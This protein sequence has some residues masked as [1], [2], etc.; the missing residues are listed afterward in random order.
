MPWTRFLVLFLSAPLMYLL[1]DDPIEMDVKQM[2]GEAEFY[3]NVERM[4]T[5]SWFCT[6]MLSAVLFVPSFALQSIPV[7][8]GVHGAALVWS[9]T[10]FVVSKL[11]GERR[12]EL[13]FKTGGGYARWRSRALRIVEQYDNV[14]HFYYVLF[15][16][17]L[18]LSALFFVYCLAARQDSKRLLICSFVVLCVA[19]SYL[20]SLC[21]EYASGAEAAR[22]T[23]KL[24]MGECNWYLRPRLWKVLSYF[25]T[26]YDK[27]SGYII[28][29]RECNG[30]IADMSSHSVNMLD[31]LSIAMLR[32]LKKNV[33]YVYLALTL[34]E[35]AWFCVLL[36][37]GMVAVVAFRKSGRACQRPG[38]KV[39]A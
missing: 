39:F 11:S 38:S 10:N 36:V 8:L 29:S 16:A 13:R 18:L 21:T 7:A 12:N 1:H 4:T 33:Q 23:L 6:F 3:G 32:N 17:C 19:N 22:S 26:V 15:L 30:H 25:T 9:G 2:V 35:K 5:I 20:V 14:E 34:W 37:L 27:E 31:A 28:N 24:F